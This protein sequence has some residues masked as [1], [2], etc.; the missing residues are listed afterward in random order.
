M[1][2][3]L[4]LPM[5]SHCLLQ[6][7]ASASALAPTG[8]VQN[9]FQIEYATFGELKVPNDEY[10]GAQTTRS[11]M[12]F[13]IGGVT[14]HMPTPVI[15]AFVAAEVN[16][17]YGLEPK[18]AN[19]IKKAADEVVEGKLNVHFPLVV[20]QTGSGAQTNMNV[21]EVISNRA[22]A[23]LKGELGSKKLVHPNDHVIKVRA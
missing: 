5:R 21:N 8:R 20:W 10:Y 18:I 7:T 17:D 14:E 3:A 4:W 2:Q 12:S 6:A 19:A 9:S 22:I 23:M 1:Y 15:K 11:T 16:Q 13:K